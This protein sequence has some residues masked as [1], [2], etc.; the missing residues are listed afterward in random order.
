MASAGFIQAAQEGML[1]IKYCPVCDI[2][3][4]FT[5]Y[6][7]RNCGSANMD[8]KT[9]LGRGHIATYT[10]I[11]VPPAGF[12]EYTPYAFVVM[13]IDNTDLR[14]SGFMGGIAA[15]ADLPV[16][17]RAHITGYDE[18]GLIIEKV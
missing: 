2:Q 14:I 8:I 7:C 5:T 3:H 4:Q 6:F 18:R 9:V 11:T 15:P 10:I 13:S 16:G 1:Q 12:E 17:T